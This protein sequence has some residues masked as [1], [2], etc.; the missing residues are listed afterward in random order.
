MPRVTT[1]PFV[2]VA[3]SAFATPVD[4]GAAHDFLCAKEQKRPRG[5]F[6]RVRR[7]LDV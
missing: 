3:L 5:F 6:D 1:A 7:D 2:G 4:K